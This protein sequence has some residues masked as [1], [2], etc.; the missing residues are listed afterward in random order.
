[1]ETFRLRETVAGMLSNDYKERIKAEYYQLKIRYTSLCRILDKIDNKELDFTPL[2][3]VEMLKQQADIMHNY[4]KI[5]EA[6]AEI[7]RIDL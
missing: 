7:E 6:R 2:T 5:L 3:P 4:M 1:M